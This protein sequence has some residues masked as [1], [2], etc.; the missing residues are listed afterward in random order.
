[1]ADLS[2][3]LTVHLSEPGEVA[4]A[5]P[6]LLG[7]RPRESLVVVSLRGSRPVRCGLTVRVDLPPPG[8]RTAVVGG[9][10]RSI[11]TDRPSGV[12][13]AVVSDVPRGSGG[14]PH[15]DVVHEA[16]RGF[17][18]CGL[19]VPTTLLVRRDRWWDYDCPDA[20]CAPDA[21]TP[22]PAGTSALAVASTVNGQV[23][24]DDRAELARRIAPVGFLAAAGMARAC[25]EVG[26]ALARRTA[27][28]G[29]DVVAEEGWAA[30]LAAV[31]GAGPGGG[32]PLTDVEVARLAWWLRDVDLRDRALALTLGSSAAAAEAV[33]T[34]LT[35]RSPVPLDAAPA[36][37]LAVSAWVRGD[38]T[39]ANVALDR[40]LDS[41]PSNSLAG[42]LR[43]ALDACLPPAEV[44]RLIRQVCRPADLGW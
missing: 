39:L 4:A 35:R 18:A 44:R 17:H 36:T 19:A 22:L 12:I 20:C 27:E 2:A 25:D 23:L 33:F 14:L 21:G 41:E 28:Q 10:V 38:G 8:H 29:W 7:F 30:L 26:D 1:M 24:A 40:A 11:L 32:P 43:S 31:A 6:H 16:V 3:P 5:V 42:L 9:V 15:R 34:E 13:V 37:L